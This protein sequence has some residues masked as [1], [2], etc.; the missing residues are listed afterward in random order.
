MSEPPQVTRWTHGVSKDVLNAAFREYFAISQEH[1]AVLVVLYT[2]PGEWTKAG[3]MQVLLDSHRPPSRQVVYERIRVLREAMD[4]ES[5]SSGGQLNDTG[6]ALT[7]PGF[8]ECD[9]ALR[10]MAE[11]L[12]RDCPVLTV[13]GEDDRAPLRR[14]A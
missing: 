8:R 6:Y 1:A 9:R 4:S 7:G 3:R 14:T 12:V 13:E 2:R 10:A 11:A 5:I